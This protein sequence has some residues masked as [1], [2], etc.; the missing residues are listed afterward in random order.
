MARRYGRD[1]VG[2]LTENGDLNLVFTSQVFHPENRLIDHSF[3]FVGPSL[4]P[5]TRDG[6]FPFDELGHGPVI[7]ISLGTI[8]HLDM[9]FYRAVFEAFTQYPAQFILAAGKQT[10][11]T[12][13]GAIPTNFVVRHYV[14]QLAI[15]ERADAFIT[16]GG[17]N[18]V[19]EGVYYGV[20]EVV[21]PH[22]IEQLLNGKRVAQTGAGLLL[23]DQ[24]PWGRVTAAA[25][26]VALD[27]V[28]QD[29]SYPYHAARIGRTLK[30]SGGYRRA[31]EEIET[32]I[33][34]HQPHT[35]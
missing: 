6:E 4:N 11:I 28:L 1:T 21:V 32:F 29:P 13:L 2:G 7:Y 12:Q 24:Y 16:H 25:L 19:H 9:G 20:P 23:G 10:D 27:A 22:Q 35:V 33:G 30:A 15:L 31:V 26:R 18:S 14:P 3:R 17:M 5:A 34:V 8:N